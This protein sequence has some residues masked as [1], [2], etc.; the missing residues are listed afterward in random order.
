MSGLTSV[1]PLNKSDKQIAVFFTLFLLKMDGF[2]VV[3]LFL[4]RR[5]FLTWLYSAARTLIPNGALIFTIK[6]HFGREVRGA[7]EFNSL[8]VL[9]EMQ[10]WTQGMTELGRCYSMVLLNTNG[11]LV[12]IILGQI[13][14]LVVLVQDHLCGNPFLVCSCL[15]ICVCFI[16]HYCLFVFFQI[17]VILVSVEGSN[18]LL[19]ALVPAI[20]EL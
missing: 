16:L 17:K 15:S 13:G 18:L 14:A 2:A 7:G 11:S 10:M 19:D 20:S 1:A 5:L 12:S 3:I 4:I 9:V 8:I 6:F